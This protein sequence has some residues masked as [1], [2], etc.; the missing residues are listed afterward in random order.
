MQRASATA[1]IRSQAAAQV[2]RA[3]V[4]GVKLNIILYSSI[5]I[6]LRMKQ[7]IDPLQSSLAN[8]S[9]R[10]FAML[11]N[12]VREHWLEHGL[13]EVS[14]SISAPGQTED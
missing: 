4:A 5:I 13:Q 12:S 10:R 6:D 7:R 3:S 9:L 8:A 11:V 2:L 14:A 1:C